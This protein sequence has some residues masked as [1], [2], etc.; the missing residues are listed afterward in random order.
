MFLERGV[1]GVAPLEE[2]LNDAEAEVAR[3]VHDANCVSG[4]VERRC[5]GSV[6][7]LNRVKKWKEKKR[8]V[9]FINR[10]RAASIERAWG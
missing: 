7:K 1:H 5:H 4:C 6:L 8:S 2:S 9:G 10:R 3:S